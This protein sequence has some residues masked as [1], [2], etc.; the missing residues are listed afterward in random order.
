M[1]KSLGA[2]EFE[3]GQ[4]LNLWGVLEGEYNEP[5][6]SGINI[7]GEIRWI[8]ARQ[9]DVDAHELVKKS[10]LIRVSTGEELFVKKFEPSTSSGFVVIRLT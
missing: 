1:L 10:K 5:E 8:E 7:E 2:E 3:T 6:L 4:V 9:S